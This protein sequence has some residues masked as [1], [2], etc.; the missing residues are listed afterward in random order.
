MI[1]NITF[2]SNRLPLNLGKQSISKL[3][4]NLQ[5]A[6]KNELAAKSHSYLSASTYFQPA[7]AVNSL[8]HNVRSFMHSRGALP[9]PV[10]NQNAKLENAEI[11]AFNFF[12]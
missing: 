8:E 7:R 4:A 11:P 12:G 1:Q 3:E 6:L 2:T 9:N 10:H 5:E